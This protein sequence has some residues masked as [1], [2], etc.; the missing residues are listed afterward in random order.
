MVRKKRHPK[1]TTQAGSA[2]KQGNARRPGLTRNDF[3][4]DASDFTETEPGLSDSTPADFRSETGFAKPTKRALCL[5]GGAILIVVLATW[6]SQ[7][8]MRGFTGSDETIA[9]HQNV[10]LLSQQL[11][12]LSKR[13]FQ[14]TELKPSE[15]ELRTWLLFDDRF[16]EENSGSALFRYETATT[17]RRAGVI[18]FTLGDAQEAHRNFAKA[19]ELYGLLRAEHPENF[20]YTTEHMWLRYSQAHL[21]ATEGQMQD[22]RQIAEKTIRTITLDK[23]TDNVEREESLAVLLAE[24]A[25]LAQ[26]LGDAQLAN[27]FAERHLTALDLLQ[28]EFPDESMFRQMRVA[29]EQ[30][31][32][33]DRPLP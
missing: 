9:A 29:T 25:R 3:V 19:D 1:S 22:A 6:W 30:L 33:V 13:F 16:I 17:A 11:E 21:Y 7:S 20:T 27:Q 18:A 32:T 28:R 8:L 26:R 24:W 4:A 31:M 23:V 14:S 5:I 15:E 10:I 2:V 12:Q